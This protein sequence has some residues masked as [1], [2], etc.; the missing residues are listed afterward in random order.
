MQD[1]GKNTNFANKKTIMEEILGLQLSIIVPVYNVEKYVRPCMESIFRQGLDEDC[2]EVIIVNDGT[3]DHSMEVIQDIIDQHKNIIVINQENQGLSV[4]RNNGIAMAKGGYILMPD[5]DDMLIDNSLKPLLEIAI[6]TKADII[7]ADFLKMNSEEINNF[8]GVCNADIKIEEK[9]GEQLT[10]EDLNVNQCYVWR[11]LFRRNFI[12]DN[13][14]SFYPG[15]SFQDVPFTH[16]C[17]I[18]ADRCIRTSRQFYIYRKGRPE[19][20]TFSYSLKK[21]KDF[22]MVIARTWELTKLNNPPH[23]QHKLKEDIFISFSNMVYNT[24]F[25]K[26]KSE[27][28]Q[29]IDYMKQLVPD[30][31]FSN[32][33]RQIIYTFM[34]KN[35]PYSLI[36]IRYIYGIVFDNC[37]RPFYYHWLRRP[38]QEK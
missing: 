9:T 17:Y 13:Q 33:L 35:M 19:A 18:K 11:S 32:G 22:C 15:V 26:S 2:F 6:E 5:S 10:I 14:I 25:M 38:F 7:V 16:E 8:K 31:A 20:A 3:E 21:G 27:K 12:V 24:A 37:I 34:Y 28:Q 1:S 36:T 29:I 4:A 23:I 30:L